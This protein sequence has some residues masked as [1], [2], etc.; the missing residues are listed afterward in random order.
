[1]RRVALVAKAVGP[2]TA[3]TKLMDVVAAHT[4]DDD[5][6]LFALAKSLGTMSSLV[7]AGHAGVLLAP[8]TVIAGTEETVVR[9]EVCRCSWHA[10]RCIVMSDCCC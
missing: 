10:G 1:M 6:V 5:E 2:E 4:D 7:G 9:D 8:L 3:R